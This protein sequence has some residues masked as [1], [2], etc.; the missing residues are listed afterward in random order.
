MQNLSAARL[1]QATT[2]AVDI[3]DFM[4]RSPICGLDACISFRQDSP[5]LN[6]P[7]LYLGE[8]PSSPRV[9][10]IGSGRKF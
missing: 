8:E 9:S 5:V 6:A 10:L 2:F 4:S 7:G 3:R 1:Y